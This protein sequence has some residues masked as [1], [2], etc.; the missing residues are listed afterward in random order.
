MGPGVRGKVVVGGATTEG[1]ILLDTAATETRV[2][3]ATKGDAERSGIAARF[4]L[5]DAFVAD[6]AAGSS[7]ALWDFDAPSGKGT[8]V[9]TLETD[10]FIHW[11]VRFDTRD[12]R[13]YFSDDG[14]ACHAHALRRAGLHRMDTAGYYQREGPF[15]SVGKWAAPTVPTVA[16]EIL[17]TRVRAQLDT[18]FE[19]PE[20]EVQINRPLFSALAG[21]LGNTTG[22]T[23]V[24]GLPHDTYVPD[25]GGVDFIDSDSGR[26]FARVDHPKFLVKPGDAAIAGWDVPA[27]LLSAAVIFRAFDV[28]ELRADQKAVWGS[29]RIGAPPAPPGTP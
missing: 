20:L 10:V 2:R 17:G 23:L 13:A 9:A 24:G 28:V 14:A 19:G 12:N 22:Q 4:L 8:Q 15:A 27:A 5:G 18:G 26:S 25:D 1:W 11:A 29:P 7:N 21:R 16:I 6:V 3:T